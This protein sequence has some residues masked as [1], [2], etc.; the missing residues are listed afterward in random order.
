MGCYDTAYCLCPWCDDRQELQSKGGRCDFQNYR[1]NEAPLDVLASIDPV[2]LCDNCGGKFE[3]II[4][5]NVFIE[6][7]VE[8]PNEDNCE[9]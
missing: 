2:V 3:I 7:Y 8:V 5:H 9:Y 6:K 4:K 1:I